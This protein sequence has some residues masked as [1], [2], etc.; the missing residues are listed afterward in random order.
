[1]VR[2]RLRPASSSHPLIAVPHSHG[3]VTHA[4]LDKDGKIHRQSLSSPSDSLKLAPLDQDALLV[5]F[6]RIDVRLGAHP[7]PCGFARRRRTLCFLRADG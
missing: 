7:P 1:M 6:D 5:M 3:P 4:D 2:Q